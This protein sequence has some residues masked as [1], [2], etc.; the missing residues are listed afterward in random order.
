MP[1]RELNN[2]ACIGKLKGEPPAASEL[3]GLL[4]SGS[5]RLAERARALLAKTELGVSNLRKSVL[6]AFSTTL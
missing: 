6:A 1:S 3:S 5:V 2:L 4:R